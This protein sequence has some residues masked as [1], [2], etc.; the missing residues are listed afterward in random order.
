MRAIRSC[1]GEIPPQ[2]LLCVRLRV[3]P[4]GRAG[5]WMFLTGSWKAVFKIVDLTNISEM[6]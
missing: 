3:E 4:I 1:S 2:S 5:S 6:K